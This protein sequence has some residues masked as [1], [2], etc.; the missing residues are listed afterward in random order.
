MASIDMPRDP[1]GNKIA[2]S[3]VNGTTVYDTAGTKLGHV[4]D[5]V[6]DKVSGQTD[7]A[8]LSFG[9][10]LGI[11][12]RYHPLPW[13]QLRYDTELGGYVIDR[14]RAQLEGAPHYDADDIGT[15]SGGQSQAVDSYY[16]GGDAG[17]GAEPIR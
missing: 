16:G 12:D 14:D 5:I 7:Y 13:P 10:F 17:L 1:G 3:Q 2:A 9:G 6:I 15:W 8:V 11:G 4:Y